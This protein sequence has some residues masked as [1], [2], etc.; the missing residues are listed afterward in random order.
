MDEKKLV[1][2]LNRGIKTLSQDWEVT[3]VEREVGFMIVP[4]KQKKGCPPPHVDKVQVFVK[5]YRY[6][7]SL[8]KSRPETGGLLVNE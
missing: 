7:D 8:L 5:V 6:S 2:A 3:A 1:R 4:H